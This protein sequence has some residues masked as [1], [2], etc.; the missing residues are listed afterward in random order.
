MIRMINDAN[1]P[2]LNFSASILNHK[3]YNFQKRIQELGMRQS[4]LSISSSSSPIW[5][6]LFLFFSRNKLLR[7]GWGTIN[8]PLL[9]SRQSSLPVSLNNLIPLRLFFLYH[10]QPCY[11]YSIS[12][13]SKIQSINL[14]PNLPSSSSCLYLPT[15][16]H[17]VSGSFS[18][19][20]ITILSKVPETS[21][22]FWAPATSL[23]R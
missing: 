10:S 4:I 13:P 2:H 11:H 7:P 21:V 23:E 14:R 12:I 6:N 19:E 9:S 22:P 15:S 1:D 20:T 16:N 3:K 17:R 8:P 18:R 5:S